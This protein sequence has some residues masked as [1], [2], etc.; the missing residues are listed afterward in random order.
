MVQLKPDQLR[1]RI[2]INSQKFVLANEVQV[3]PV[4]SE[5]QSIRTIGLQQRQNNRKVN[6]LV[7]DWSDGLGYARLRRD[8][9]RG[10]NGLRDADAETRFSSQLTLP[11]NPQ[12]QTHASPSDH[13]VSYEHFKG[14]LFG[15]FEEDYA[16]DAITEVNSRKFNASTDAWDSTATANDPT[17]N[18]VSEGEAS[19][20]TSVTR[21]HTVSSNDGRLV[22]VWCASRNNTGGAAAAFPSGVTFGG[23]ACTLLTQTG[24]GDFNCFSVYFLPNAPAGAGDAVVTYGASQAKIQI[25]VT[26]YY[27]TNTVNPIRSHDAIHANTGDS[28]VLTTNVSVLDD[29]LVIGAMASNGEDGD[30]ITPGTGQTERIDIQHSS[31]GTGTPRISVS[32]ERPDGNNASFEHKYTAT[33]RGTG[34]DF[35]SGMIVAV[36]AA[37]NGIF[38]A[39][40]SNAVGLRAFDTTVY[41]GSLYVIGT[42][43][44]TEGAYI[45]RNSTSGGDWS[46]ATNGGNNWPTDVYVHTTETRKNDWANKYAGILGFGTNLIA[47]IY[48]DPDS[49]A[50]SI[51]QIRVGY[52]A[53]SGASWTFN[54]GLIIPSGTAPNITL[55]SARDIFSSNSETIPAL[56]TSEN[57]YLLDIANNTFQPLLP[58]GILAGTANEA[59]AATHASD[60]AVYISKASGDILRIA[61]PSPGVIDIK[62]IGP[63]SKAK[64]ADS[65]GL[66]SDRQGHANFMWGGDPRWLFVSYGGHESGKYASVF[67]FDYQTGAWHSFYKD[68][69]ANR[70]TNR[71]IGSDES[72]G[73]SRIHISTEHADAS[74]LQHFEE[75]YVPAIT[76]ATQQYRSTGYV[77]WAE[78]DLGDP[79][80]DSAI[81]TVR[82]DADGLDNVSTIEGGSGT[83]TDVEIEY[84]LNGAAWDNV[85][86]LGFVGS[87]D[88][89]LFFGKTNQNTPGASE[90]GTPIGVSAKTFR[91]R[92][93]LKRDGTITNTPKIK[94]IQ[95]EHVNKGED[96]NGFVIAIDVGATAL[97]Q[98]INPE[99]VLDRIDTIKA[100]VTSVALEFGQETDGTVTTYYVEHVRRGQ[101]DSEGVLPQGVGYGAVTERTVNIGTVTMY[102]EERIDV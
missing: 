89:V 49:N 18:A 63:H 98:Q 48:E 58:T 85:S 10:I 9:N 88:L 30:T 41:K 100:S 64:V 76:G 62:N 29:E 36:L 37:P 60:G 91:M 56:V 6:K 11:L 70:D 57:V 73:V 95:T 46:G 94:E 90:A 27:N 33:D 44:D 2:S 5:S 23:T 43:Q 19:A 68:G 83:S 16:S 80:V 42:S 79:H 53:D 17:W 1:K 26:D 21:S 97:D 96:L 12:T 55:I 67:C 28:G 82:V 20:A 102:L 74:I 47:A 71:L 51:S 69:T 92:A 93:E 86:T 32:D 66:V 31:S 13:L 65:D 38:G 45:W 34:I 77:E 50:G 25:V 78:D 8:T 87:D 3:Y 101:F 54:A 99:V 4:D 59:L 75:P 52:S 72:D 35:L 81:L 40:T 24:G 14:D 61:I 7:R 39:G 22:V 15:I 84:G